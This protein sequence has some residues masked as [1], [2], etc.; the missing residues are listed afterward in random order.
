MAEKIIRK[1]GSF[2]LEDVPAEEVFTPEDFG[3]EHIMIVR[4]TERFIKNEVE[5]QIDVMEHKEEDIEGSFAMTRK[6][7]LKAGELGLLGVDIEE[8]YGGAE[9]D[10]IASLLICEH[11]ALSGSFGLTM[12]DHTG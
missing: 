10:V 8:K 2:F 6:L 9:M 7:M 1:G 12:N 3:D 11:S 4:T 5:P